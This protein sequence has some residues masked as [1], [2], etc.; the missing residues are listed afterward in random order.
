V[1]SLGKFHDCALCLNLP[2]HPGTRKVA[3]DNVT[4]SAMRYIPLTANIVD[5]NLQLP[6]YLLIIEPC[7]LFQGGRFRAHR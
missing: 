3:E 1:L 4:Y 7:Y 2:V 6:L 5:T